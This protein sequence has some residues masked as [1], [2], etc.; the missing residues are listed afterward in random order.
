ME[1]LRIDFKSNGIVA[2]ALLEANKWLQNQKVTVINV[3][4]LMESAP[5]SIGSAGIREA[6]IRVWYTKT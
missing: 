2:N 1:I 5:T 6:G 3:E 4:T